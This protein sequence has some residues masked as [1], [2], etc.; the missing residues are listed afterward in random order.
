MKR[1]TTYAKRKETRA[2]RAAVWGRSDGHC[3]CGCG[4][5]LG[6]PSDRGELDHF[7][8]RAKAS[9]AVDNCWRL[10]TDCHRNKTNN[11]PDAAHWLERYIE[12]CERHGY[13]AEIEWACG[14]IDWLAAKGRAA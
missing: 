14:R 6:D 12:H 2:I 3:E 8:G 5:F 9:Q 10:A 11:L 1:Q 7:R 4:V 13:G